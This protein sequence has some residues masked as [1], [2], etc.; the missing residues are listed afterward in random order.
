MAEKGV[1]VL[2]IFSWWDFFS[3]SNK[4]LVFEQF[5]QATLLPISSTPS[6][7][8]GLSISQP[9][10]WMEETAIFI[11]QGAEG[12]RSKGIDQD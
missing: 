9:E 12:W 3:H 6:Y 4:H 8:E 7:P 1:S 11:L 5:I 10:G 2:L